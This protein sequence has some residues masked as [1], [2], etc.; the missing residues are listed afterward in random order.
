M[1]KTPHV[2]VIGKNLAALP[3]RLNASKN[4]RVGQR[5]RDLARKLNKARLLSANG[6]NTL[7]AR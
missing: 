1:D 7:L 6:M 3:Q 5:Q 2:E 4:A